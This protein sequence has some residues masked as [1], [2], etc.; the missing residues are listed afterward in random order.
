[1]NAIKQYFSRRAVYDISCKIIIIKNA[2]GGT[3]EIGCHILKK[4]NIK[5]TNLSLVPSM[6]SVNKIPVTAPR[7]GNLST[8][9]SPVQT[10]AMIKN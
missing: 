3:T 10:K 9:S 4:N 5:Q 7:M 2:F 6:S 1:M 8:V